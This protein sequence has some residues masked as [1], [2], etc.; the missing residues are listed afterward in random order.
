MKTKSIEF[1]KCIDGGDLTQFVEDNSDKDWNTIC[2]I[3]REFELYGDEGRTH[4]YISYNPLLIIYKETPN[5]IFYQEMINKFYEAYGLD[6]KE[7][8]IVLFND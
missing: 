8:L 1:W 2:V 4:G 7:N 3:E 5:K 6:P